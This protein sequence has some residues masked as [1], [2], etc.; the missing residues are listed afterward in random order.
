MYYNFE[1]N[2]LDAMDKLGLEPWEWIEISNLL[3]DEDLIRFESLLKGGKVSVYRWIV[4]IKEIVKY[5]LKGD[6]I[7]KEDIK[8]YE[9]LLKK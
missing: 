6:R 4:Y 5:L 3:T 8:R 1:N 9:I 7:K 2:L